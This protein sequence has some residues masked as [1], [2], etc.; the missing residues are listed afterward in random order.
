MFLLDLPSHS[1]IK[2][3]RFPVLVGSWPPGEIFQSQT[4]TERIQVAPKK[5]PRN[6]FSRG[7]LDVSKNRG[8]PKW[9]FIMVNPIRMDDLGVPRF[10]ETPSFHS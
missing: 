3:N 1:G 8:I 4:L 6:S 7:E 9:M 10:L 5:F 2:L